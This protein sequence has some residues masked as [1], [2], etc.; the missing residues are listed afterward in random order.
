MPR[1]KEMFRDYV[2]ELREVFG[3]DTVFLSLNKVAKYLKK[4]AR[5]LLN[6]KTFP[7]KK[8][9]GRYEVPLMSLARWLA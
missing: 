4:D 5:T 8:V 1:E 6:D 9:C 3:S 2:A 7:V